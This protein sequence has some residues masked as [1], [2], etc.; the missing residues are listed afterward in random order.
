MLAAARRALDEGITRSMPAEKNRSP[1]AR[2]ID[3]GL[4]FISGRIKPERERHR[5]VPPNRRCSFSRSV[6]LRHGLR[7]VLRIVLRRA[8][9]NA[10]Q[11]QRCCGVADAGVGVNT[12]G[13]NAP[14]F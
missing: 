1:L 6:V 5:D 4:A 9:P 12:A 14:P 2:R 3:P 7:Q 8:S 10:K 13:R 11:N